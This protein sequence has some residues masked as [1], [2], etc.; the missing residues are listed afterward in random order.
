MFFGWL[1]KYVP[2]GLYGRA[3]LILLVP[4]VVIQLV[5]IVAFSQ[6]Y[7]NDI[8]HQLMRGVKAETALFVTAA[9]RGDDAGLAQLDQ[10][11]GYRSE[12]GA[13]AQPVTTARPFY[14]V[15]SRV[16]ED[17]LRSAFPTLDGV[18]VMDPR[19]LRFSLNLESGRLVLDLPRERASASNPHQMLVLTLGTGVL[20]TLIAFVYL[21]NQLRPIRRL[22]KAAEAFG[23]GESKPYKPRGAVEVRSAGAA[24][25]NMRAR[26]ERHL[27]QRTLMLSG[28][29]H[30]LRTP[31]TRLR[32]GLSMLADDPEKA[33]EVADMM[34]DIDEME[35]LIDGFL[36]FSRAATVEE[37]SE[38]DVVELVR[39]CVGSAERAGGSVTF[40]PMPQHALDMMARPEALARAVD[41]LLSNTRRYAHHARVSVKELDRSVVISVEDD[42]PGIVSDMRDRAQM[43]FVR[44]DAARNQNKGSGVGLGLAIAT[45]VAR[46]HGGTLRLGESARLGGLQADIVLPRG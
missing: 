26:I 6:R 36:D 34:G 1:K 21:R 27:E 42:G 5:V 22:A 32:L 45:D 14:D 9:N 29:S 12:F 19:R 2:R 37:P 40:G 17:D 28:V 7:F 4:V 33:D 3:A 8:T 11:L 10:T 35:R 16:I 20:M 18:N 23:R 41:N 24:F 38:I 13:Q 39:T 44:L 30:D 31:L 15:S 43:P 25:L 46:R